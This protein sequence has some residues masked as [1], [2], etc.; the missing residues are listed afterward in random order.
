MT[1]ENKNKKKYYIQ[2]NEKYFIPNNNTFRRN[3]PDTNSFIS[4]LQTSQINNSMSYQKDENVSKYPTH[5]LPDIN[6][7]SAK[8]LTSSNINNNKNKEPKILGNEVK[9]FDYLY[10]PRTTFVLQKEEEEKLYQDLGVGF[11]PMSI[12]IM[13]SYFKEKLGVLNEIE[14][15]GI[16]KNH[17]LSWHPELPNREEIL[18]KLLSRLFR[19]IDINCHEEMNWDDFTDYLMYSS[20]NISTKN[21]NYDLKMYKHSSNSID[22]LNFNDLISYAF[23]IEKFNLIGV[24]IENKSVINFYDANNCKRVKAYIDVKKTQRDIDQM[25]M[26]EFEIKAREKIQKKEDE[27]KIKLLINQEYKLKRN[28]LKMRNHFNSNIIKKEKRVE[29]PEKLKNE[30][31]RINNNIDFEKKKKEFNRKLTILTSCFVNEYDLLFVSSSNNKISAWKY[32]NGDFINVNQLEDDIKERTNFSCAILD[33]T[34]PQ[35]TIDWE[36]IQ[37]ILYSGQA[38]G[39]ILYWDI[40]KSKN[41]DHYTLDYKIAKAKHDEELLRK[42][43]NFNNFEKN[44]N[45]ESLKYNT[46]N[47][48]IDLEKKD[49]QDLLFAMGEK[50]LL[51]IKND[52][53][54]ESVSCIK[55]LGK[56]QIIAAGYY[57]GNVILWDTLLHEYRKFYTDQST[58]IYQIE[59]NINKNLIFTCG[60]DHNI[61]IYDPFI[62]GNCIQKLIG[63][64]WSVNSIACNRISDELISFDINGIIKIWDLNNYYNFQSINI[65][66][67]I[68]LIKSSINISQFDSS[69][70]IASNKKMIFLS[71]ANK[72]MTYGDKFMIFSRDSSNFPDLC[73]SQII[74]GCFYNPK[75][76][77]FYTVCLKKIKLWNIFNG[78]L[79]KIYEEFLS[80]S[81][82]EITSFCTDKVINKLYIG[83]NLGQIVCI[84]LNYGNIIKEFSSH[85][86]EIINLCHSE[87][88]NL[89]ISL[90]V[91]NLIKIH[92]DKELNDNSVIKEFIIENINITTI[93]LSNDFSRLIIGTKEGEIKYYD[94]AHLKQDS[95]IRNSKFKKLYKNDAIT[96]TF[97]FEEYPICLTCHESCRN[98]FEIIPPHPYKFYYFGEF[99]SE[100]KKIGNDEITESKILSFAI[101]KEKNKIFFGDI[102]GYVT[103]YSVKK[104]LELFDNNELLNRSFNNINNYSSN[105]FNNTLNNS[106]NINNS[107]LQSEILDILDNFHIDYLYCFQSH[108]EPVKHILFLNIMPNIIITTGND[109]KV[110][111]FSENGNFIDEFKQSTEKIKE[112]PIG[113]KYYFSDPFISKRNENDIQK[114][115]NVYRKDLENFKRSK[116]RNILNRMRLENKSILEYSNKI[117][118]FNA[119]E[120]LYLLSKNCKLPKDRSTPWNYMPD[121]NFILETERKVLDKKIEEIKKIE[122]NNPIFNSYEPIYNEKYQPEF[123]KDL[124]EKK[125]KEFGELLNNKIRKVKL[126][127]SKLKVDSVKYESYEKEKKRTDNISYKNEMKMI[128]GK[129][130]KFKKF[131]SPKLIQYN[132]DKEI[133]YGINKKRFNSCNEKFDSYQEDFKRSIIELENTM[134]Q[135]LNKN[136]SINFRKSNNNDNSNNNSSYNYLNMN[137]IKK[138]KKYL[139]PFINNNGIHKKNISPTKFNKLNETSLNKNKMFNKN[140][141]NSTNNINKKNK[142]LEKLNL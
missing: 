12:K 39:K 45:L 111:I 72:I 120:R 116:N 142:S 124:D 29:T 27:N 25:E 32:I 1:E 44:Q 16:L 15:I 52:M 28:L 67:A 61:Y 65:N 108:K 130:L 107:N 71:K 102:L 66:E 22:D 132:K 56:M 119:Q 83:N 54:R 38:D 135:K 47:I 121:L 31:K 95:S 49:R 90:S 9:K 118:E 69:K 23:Y 76:Y 70:K 127:M 122:K 60:F 13:K 85:N 128:Y 137:N 3:N 34:L 43:K 35:Y 79:Y 140:D 112:V 133:I 53:N 94:I 106:D 134:E 51:N 99:I 73:D 77:L 63:H 6:V 82:T 10:S 75:L 59:Y 62:D 55:I 109:R 19:D 89:L 64:N 113:I 5:S 101:D 84:N 41:I 7:T 98:I 42:N 24:V 74:L 46:K 126:A 129:K 97:I 141:F 26:K 114:T 87:H 103:C 117:T 50:M 33:A 123:I 139:L 40:Y 8:N 58:G 21:L 20:K 80:N 88:D 37:K 110:K 30:L 105:S 18:V 138:I 48:R 91:D 81:L 86:S 4:N 104:L 11:D 68:H 2:K 17:L 36:P 125:I 92:R 131:N 115:G 78:K 136:F 93:N 14:F 100:Y 96:S 57:N